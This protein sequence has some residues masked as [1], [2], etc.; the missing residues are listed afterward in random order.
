MAKRINELPSALS[1]GLPRLHWRTFGPI[2]LFCTLRWQGE[3]TKCRQLLL[4][5]PSWPAVTFEGQPQGCALA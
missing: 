1:R 2:R 4:V 3:H 5:E